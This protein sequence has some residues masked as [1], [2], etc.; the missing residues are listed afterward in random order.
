MSDSNKRFPIN[1]LLISISLAVAGYVYS[2]SSFNDTAPSATVTS[3][4]SQ[5]YK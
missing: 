3:N 4:S 1:I 5:E 2:I